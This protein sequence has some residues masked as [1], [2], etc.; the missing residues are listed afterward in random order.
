[1][2]NKNRNKKQMNTVWKTLLRIISA[3]LTLICLCGCGKQKAH[4]EEVRR[5]AEK[6]FQRE[7][8]RK[9]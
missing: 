6:V 4:Y 7:I 5:K 8:W 9:G 3:G 1:M 2:K